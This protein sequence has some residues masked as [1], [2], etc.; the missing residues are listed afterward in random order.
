MK[1]PKDKMGIK[2]HGEE[3]NGVITIY[4]LNCDNAVCVLHR[5]SNININ[6]TT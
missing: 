2:I 5:N 3:Y 1:C 4:V 6:V